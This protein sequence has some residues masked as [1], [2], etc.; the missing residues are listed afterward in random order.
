MPRSDAHATAA[1]VQVLGHI[2]CSNYVLYS[3]TVKS[4]QYGPS[5]SLPQYVQ[6]TPALHSMSA[7]ASAMVSA[8]R[9]CSAAAAPLPSFSVQ[10]FSTLKSDC[11]ANSE[12][13]HC[14]ARQAA[15]IYRTRVISSTTP[16]AESMSKDK[17]DLSAGAAAAAAAQT[18]QQQ[19]SAHGL[20]A[21]PQ[22]AKVLGFAGATLP[23]LQARKNGCNKLCA[24]RPSRCHANV[25]SM[26]R[27]SIS[28]SFL[29]EF[30]HQTVQVLS[31]S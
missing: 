1:D 28:A 27:V 30:D 20:Q 17:T 12:R 4:C 29:D 16:A 14:R 25:E 9:Q 10:L 24:C 23:A 19:P 13:L 21:A 3:Q 7:S 26:V 31:R 5:S 6:Q 22:V 2:S 11:S 18:M 8:A 15:Q